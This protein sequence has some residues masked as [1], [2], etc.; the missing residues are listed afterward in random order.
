M[1]RG[2]TR[3]VCSVRGSAWQSAIGG[4]HPCDKRRTEGALRLRIF[5][6]VDRSHLKKIAAPLRGA[7]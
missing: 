3:A 1:R 7:Q 5:T 2:A 6:Q 4:L